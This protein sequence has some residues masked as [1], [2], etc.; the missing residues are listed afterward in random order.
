[1]LLELILAVPGALGT[2][3]GYVPCPA[4]PEKQP[5]LLKPVTQMLL[6]I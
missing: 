5:N 2:V 4:L 6:V 1:M 3:S